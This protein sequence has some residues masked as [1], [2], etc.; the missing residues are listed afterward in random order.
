[1]V[2]FASFESTRAL[3]FRFLVESALFSI[4]RELPNSRESSTE[5]FLI[6]DDNRLDVSVC[7]AE[8]LLS[9]FPASTALG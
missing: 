6:D 3:C 5:T 1:M 9:D 7:E 4:S 8:A 2:A